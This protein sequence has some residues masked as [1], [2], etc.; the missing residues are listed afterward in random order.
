MT[1]KVLGG[2][3]GGGSGGGGFL[4]PVRDAS[5]VTAWGGELWFPGGGGVAIPGAGTAFAN[6]L[7]KA[8]PY[9][10]GRAGILSQLGVE[11]TVVGGAG[12]KLRLG[13]YAADPV[14]LYP[15]TL[16]FDSGDI[17]DDAAIGIKVAALTMA[18]AAGQVVWFAY[19]NGIAAAPTVRAFA[20]SGPSPFGMLSLPLDFF[21]RIPFGLSIAQAYGAFPAIF[22]AGAAT[23]TSANEPMLAAT[24][25]SA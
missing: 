2:T 9:I 21:N 15:T 14:S 22:P 20:A 10:A 18:I 23:N 24:Y 17:A 5:A 6:G 19:N 11:I 13:V 1:V 8:I 3:G 25:A 4:R 12:G 16:L 7:L